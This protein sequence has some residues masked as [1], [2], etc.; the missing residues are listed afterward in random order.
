MSSSKAWY[1]IYT[2]PRWEKKVADRIQRQSFEIFCPVN[3]II[4]QWADRKKVIYEPLFSCYVFVRA[5]QLEELEIKKIEG[6]LNF[7]YWNNKP[8]VIKDAEIDAIKSFLEKNNTVRLEKIIIQQG[9]KVRINNGAFI[10]NEGDVIEVNNKLI[11]IMLPSIGY[12]IVA[13]VDKNK[14]EVISP[15][16]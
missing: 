9:D 5:T 13:E 7:V 8:A 4:K 16:K 11:K 15:H 10:H 12:A 1:A 3:K 14:L 6:V 2:R